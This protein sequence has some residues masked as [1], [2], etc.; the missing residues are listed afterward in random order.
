[1]AGAQ[2][3]TPA[4]TN[5]SGQSAPQR[6]VALSA[7]LGVRVRCA[8]GIHALSV[9]GGVVRIDLFQALVASGKQK[10]QV[11]TDCVVL[12]VDA[13]NALLRMLQVVAKATAK[14]GSSARSD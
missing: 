14:G 8:D 6:R 3:K 7:S 12:P 13:V 2:D 11:V 5:G 4:T 1:M 10:Q 9:R